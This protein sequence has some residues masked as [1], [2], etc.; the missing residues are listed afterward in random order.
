MAQAKQPKAT[1]F[2]NA[3]VAPGDL[4]FCPRERHCTNRLHTVR[5]TQLAPGRFTGLFLNIRTGK[6][7]GVT[8]DQNANA[9]RGQS[10]RRGD[11]RPGPDSS[12]SPRWR[13]QT[14]VS[15][16]AESAEWLPSMFSASAE[17]AHSVAR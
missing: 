8:F 3:R 10:S 17:A 7:G 12:N 4:S 16:G 15:T 1:R 13:T 11:R 9:V 2:F 6:R 5:Y 14:Q